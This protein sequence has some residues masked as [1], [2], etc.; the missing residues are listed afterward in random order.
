VTETQRK[1]ERTASNKLEVILKDRVNCLAD[2]L[3]E[4]QS[5]IKERTRLS[6][7][8]LKT[9]DSEYLETKNKIL[10]LEA[11][12]LG[13]SPVIDERRATLETAL[14]TLS[15]ERRNEQVT[16]WQDSARLAQEARDRLK[17]YRDLL[18][19]T[20]ILLPAYNPSTGGRYIVPSTVRSLP[21]GEGYNSRHE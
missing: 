15:R 2:I 11:W 19:R 8:I 17:E 3:Q 21:E 18:Q 1:V 20:Q 16:S 5:S 4:V 14:S 9:I 10:S 12:P 13:S 7:A 6:K